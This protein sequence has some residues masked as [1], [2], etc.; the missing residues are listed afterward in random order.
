MPLLLAFALTLLVA[1]WIS[2]LAQR[3][4]LSTAVLFLVVGFV[5]GR[6]TLRIVALH[7]QQS[8]VESLA[9]LALFSVL[10]TDGMKASARDL[11]SAWRLPGRALLLGLPLTLAGTAV[12]AHLLTPLT[13]T[14]SF[15]LGAILSPTDPVFAAAIIGHEGVPLRLRRLLNVES[16]LND[17]IA[18]PFVL[19]LSDA[20]SPTRT[21]VLTVS[22][23]LVLGVIGGVALTWIVLQLEKI[24]FLSPATEF[25]PLNAFAIGLL[26]YAVG[27]MTQVNLFLAA[28]AA[29]VTI[30]SISPGVKAAF[31][32]FGEQLAR[33]LKLGALLMFGALISPQIVG[34]SFR[35]G[36]YI[37]VLLA[38]LIVRPVAIGI[39]LLGSKIEI[40]EWIAAAWF[41]PRGFASMIYALLV[42]KTG[43]PEAEYLFHL[44]A[45][46]IAFSI[47]AHSSSDVLVA[48]WFHHREENKE[49]KQTAEQKP[50]EQ[51]AHEQPQEQVSEEEPAEKP[52]QE[53]PEEK[54][55]EKERTENPRQ[56]QQDQERPVR[57]DSNI[58]RPGQCHWR[59]L[60][61]PG[62]RA[63]LT[64]SDR[65]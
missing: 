55:T 14:Q 43:A 58:D 7:P 27:S 33:L 53:Q 56:E 18:L 46:V 2:G 51:P 31:S 52:V 49:E 24:R 45:L 22:A 37:F 21:G 54:A 60:P 57:D 38:L 28:F 65:S 8:L 64:L 19:L 5:T 9:N 59:Y 48:Q 12:L 15:L 6:G 62:I 35:L 16:G 23:E 10:F 32:Q 41:G 25:E 42:L 36:D 11:A 4:V 34:S 26:I 17:G 13:W 29:A 50:A 30:A 44:V 63:I 1:V 3:T 20:V 47:I 39:A 40:H 61:S